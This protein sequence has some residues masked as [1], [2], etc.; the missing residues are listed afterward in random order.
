[1]YKKILVGVDGS[2]QGAK[3]LETA[4]KLAQT[5]KADLF[6]FHAIRHHFQLPVFPLTMDLSHQ[7]PMLD[8][9]ISD[10]KLQQYYEESGRQIIEQAKLQV[11]A[12]KVKLDGKVTYALETTL[13]PAD[14]AEDFAKTNK[15]DLIVLGCLGHHSRAKKILLGTVANKITNRAPCQVLIV[16]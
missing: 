15:V 8:V 16:R 13:S 11:A 12:L 1:M 14:Y 4:V 7:T 5:F 9:G 10:D 3:A 2:P 6:V